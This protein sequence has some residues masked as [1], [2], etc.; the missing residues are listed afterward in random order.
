MVDPTI[1]RVRYPLYGIRKNKIQV[2]Y[3][4]VCTPYRADALFEV[5]EAKQLSK[6]Y[7]DTYL[8]GISKDRET[9]LFF[10][11]TLIDQM[12]NTKTLDYTNLKTT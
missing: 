10:V 6:R 9:A 1:K 11:T 12:F 4:L 2:H 8:V 5:I 7:D 3:Y